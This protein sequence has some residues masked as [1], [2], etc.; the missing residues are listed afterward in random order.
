MCNRS[1]ISRNLMGKYPCHI[2]VTWPGYDLVIT[3]IMRSWT[4]LHEVFLTTGES[5]RG[6]YD[7][8]YIDR[9][10]SAIFSHFTTFGEF[11]TRRL[12]C[13]YSIMLHMSLV[14]PSMPLRVY[15]ASDLRFPFPTKSMDVYSQKQYFTFIRY[16]I[17]YWNSIFNK[18]FAII[19]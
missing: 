9:D 17:T 8:P 4:T 16:S 7:Q 19:R 13:W 15:V 5:Q 6:N 3:S 12:P 1:Y 14:L 11:C 18:T 10:F 2:L